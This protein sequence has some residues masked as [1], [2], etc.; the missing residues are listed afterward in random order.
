MEL[1]E[2]RQEPAGQAVRAGGAPGGP[3]GLCPM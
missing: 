3:G 2:V 1:S